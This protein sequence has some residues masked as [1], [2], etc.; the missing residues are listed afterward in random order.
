MILV[1][2][3]IL[4]DYLRGNENRQTERFDEVLSKK[5][6]FGINSYIY[7]ELLQGTASEKEF[8]NLKG[9]LDTQKIYDLRKG[10][11]PFEKAALMYYKCRKSGLTINST[12]DFLIVETAIENSLMLFHNDSDFTKIAKIIKELR[13][14]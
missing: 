4:I 5:I 3:S 1:D 2:T 12:I 8:A 13:I 6:P 14:Y 7:L 11:E 9:Y 10:L